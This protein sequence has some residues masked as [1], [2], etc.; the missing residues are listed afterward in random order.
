MAH[1]LICIN[2]ENNHSLPVIHQKAF[3]LRHNIKLDDLNSL[4]DLSVNKIGHVTCYEFFYCIKKKLR[5]GRPD[6]I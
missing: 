4:M 3:K 1:C 5:M 2:P 6:A